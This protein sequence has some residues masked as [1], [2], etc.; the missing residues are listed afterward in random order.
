METDAIR[1]EATSSSLLT[2]CPPRAESFL[3][4]VAAFV[5]PRSE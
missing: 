1:R 5:L 3:G 2:E 4:S